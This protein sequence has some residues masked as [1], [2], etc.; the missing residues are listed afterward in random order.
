MD[1]ENKLTF[2]LGLKAEEVKHTHAH[3]HTHARTHTHAHCCQQL[4]FSDSAEQHAS[5]LLP[6]VVVVVVVVG[7]CFQL[8]ARVSGPQRLICSTAVKWLVLSEV[9]HVFACSQWKERESVMVG[10]WNNS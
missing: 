2:C 9:S 4:G 3:T 6:V 10:Q 8:L 7:F 5:H 1:P